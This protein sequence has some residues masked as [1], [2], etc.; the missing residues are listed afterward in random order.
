MVPRRPTC[1]SAMM[2]RSGTIWRVLDQGSRLASP[3]ASPQ[4]QDQLAPREGD[5]YGGEPTVNGY[6]NCVPKAGNL[7]A[8]REAIGEATTQLLDFQKKGV[9]ATEAERLLKCSG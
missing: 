2:L 6:L 1:L 5:P 9:M 8:V 4:L 3:C 7:K